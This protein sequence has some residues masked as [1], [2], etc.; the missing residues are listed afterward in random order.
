MDWFKSPATGSMTMPLTVL[1]VLML[2][3]FLLS[4]RLKESAFLAENNKGEL[5]LE[6]N[7]LLT[8]N[9]KGDAQ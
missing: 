3:S 7:V 1:C 9:N 8:G 2:I 6:E 4:A 5:R